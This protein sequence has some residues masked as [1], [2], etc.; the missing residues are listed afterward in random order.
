MKRL[1]FLWLVCFVSVMNAQTLHGS[2]KGEL[3]VGGVKL[4][5]VLNVT[6][7]GKCTLD[8]PDQGA[9]GIPAELEYASQDSLSVVVKAVGA[10]YD[11][12]LKEG[13]IQGI[14][15]QAGQAFPLVLQPGG[16]ALRR[17]QT[18]VPPFDYQTEEV[19]F[20]NKEHQ[21]KLGGT[22]TYPV[23]FD[24][25][26]G[27][28]VPVV[29]MVTGSG[30]QNRDEE[31]LGHKPF[32]VLADYFAKHGIASLRY[33]DRGVGKSKASAKDITTYTN[34]VDA[35]SGVDFLKNMKCFGRIG[36]LGHSEGGTIAMMLAS[37]N[38]KKVDF[39]ISMAGAALGGDSV[40]W[41]QNYVALRMSGLSEKVA[42]D[43]CK[44]LK[45]VL[46]L[47]SED[48]QGVSGQLEDILNEVELPAQLKENLR[49]V[50]KT[51]TPWLDYFVRYN[52][53]EDI[54]GVKCPVMV[55]NG[56]LDM[57]VL[58]SSNLAAFEKL[59]PKGKKTWIK[60][61]PGLNHLFQHC[62][63]GTVAE[64]GRIEETLSE[65]VL[66]DVTEWVQ[67]LQ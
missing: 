38:K 58:P 7:D 24:R 5:L 65:E 60:E 13:R 3:N 10:R 66:R 14:F 48:N 2:W 27:K 8:S 45:K 26:N 28:S 20:E 40:L 6:S 54:S 39:V 9:K 17:P 55:I 31:I 41:E 16:V 1:V 42:G 46:H 25:S 33:D 51:M 21:V 67:G 57:Q 23:G 34:Y 22:L 53:A 52:P 36:V 30:L 63:L 43:Y 32:A 61:Y 12:K 59:L 29:L 4:R 47:M 18:P 35:L 44:T 62:V 50:Q 11:G 49:L 56:S 15:R 19:V 64:Y 37:R